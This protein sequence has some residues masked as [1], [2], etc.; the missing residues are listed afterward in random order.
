MLIQMLFA[1]LIP[2][3]EEAGSEEPKV[4]RLSLTTRAFLPLKPPFDARGPI[5]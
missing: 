1:E 4:P 3:Q 2:D 5:C